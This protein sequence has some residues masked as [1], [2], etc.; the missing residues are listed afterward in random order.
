[1]AIGL[2]SRPRTG[3]ARLMVMNSD[4]T[5]LRTLTDSME[6]RG[7]PV[8]SPDGQS[9]VTAARQGESPRLFRVSL[10]TGESARILDDYALDP[11][12]GPRGE[13]LVYSGMDPGTTFPVKAVSPA[14]QPHPIPEL[15]LSRGGAL[16]VTQVGARRL[17]FVPG[18]AALVVLRGDIQH[19]D[20]WATDLT[21]GEWRQLTNFGRDIVIGDF[22]V[23]PDGRSVVFERVQER[24]DIVVIDRTD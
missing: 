16:G 23:A 15:K 4:G 11:A 19:K 8:W 20:L 3:K 6:L 5:G 22:D 14:G 10:S 7:A 12:W 17:R 9:V 2:P 13:F 24:S 18:Q 1:M 21:T